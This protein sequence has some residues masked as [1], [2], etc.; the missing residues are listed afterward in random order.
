MFKWCTTIRAIN[1]NTGE[2]S[3]FEGPE[4]EAPTSKLAHEYCQNNGLGY[5]QVTG[6]MPIMSVPCKPGTYE[7]DFSKATEDNEKIWYN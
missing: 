1:P 4:I 3:T 5:C 2:L 7:P 6:D